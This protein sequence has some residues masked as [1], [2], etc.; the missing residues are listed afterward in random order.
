MHTLFLEWVLFGISLYIYYLYGRV[1][2]VNK[3]MALNLGWDGWVNKLSDIWAG[4]GG[5]NKK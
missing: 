4:L 2:G 1:V 3:I 5:E